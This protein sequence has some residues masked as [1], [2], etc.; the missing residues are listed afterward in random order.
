[1]RGTNE[2]GRTRHA[3]NKLK[4]LLISVRDFQEALSAAT[5]LLEE[6]DQ[7]AKYSLA[8]I[9]RFRCYETAMVIAYARPFSMAK[10]E[11]GPLKPK[12]TG[13]SMTAAEKSLHRKL[14][15]HRNT[16]YGHS[17]AEF[18]EMRVMVLHL[19]LDHNPAGFDWVMPRFEERMRF[20]LTEIGAIHDMLHKLVHALAHQCQKLGAA[21][22]D[23]FT[24]YKV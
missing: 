1:M 15:T 5:F 23:R 3:F 8:E 2:E 11:V 13:L 24:T 22:K 6:V 17:D 12:D 16:V 4:R 9:R 21:F 19:P 14:I 10:G 18:V 7:S 20:S